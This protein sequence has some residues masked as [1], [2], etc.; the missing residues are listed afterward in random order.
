MQQIVQCYSKGKPQEVRHHVNAMLASSVVPSGP[1]IY[2]GKREYR[3][4]HAQ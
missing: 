4:S 3:Q 1:A 2:D